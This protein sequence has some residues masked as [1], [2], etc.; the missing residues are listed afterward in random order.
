MQQSLRLSSQNKEVPEVWSVTIIGI[1]GQILESRDDLKTKML[2]FLNAY[3]RGENKNHNGNYVNYR[4]PTEIAMNATYSNS[5]NYRQAA[6]EERSHP[7]A[8]EDIKERII[9]CYYTGKEKNQDTKLTYGDDAY[10]VLE[11]KNTIGAVVDLKMSV[12]FIDF[13]E[14]IQTF[15]FEANLPSRQA[16]PSADRAGRN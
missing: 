11:T 4:S 10:L 3:F 12:K 1:V 15:C 13:I 14:V 7:T 8:T 9:D 2:A 5:R 16:G 6:R